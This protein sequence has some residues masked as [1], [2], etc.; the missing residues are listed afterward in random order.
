MK[1][2]T[3]PHIPYEVHSYCPSFPFLSFNTQMSVM[4]ALGYLAVFAIFLTAEF[5]P[6]FN[7]YLEVYNA[8]GQAFGWIML[9]LYTYASFYFFIMRRDVLYG[10][11]HDDDEERLKATVGHSTSVGKAA[12]DESKN[13][14]SLD[15]DLNLSKGAEFHI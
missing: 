1:S 13:T 6:Q 4:D 9:G 12:T 2:R 3:S 8:L 7:S 10:P 11:H 5:A 15:S 14:D